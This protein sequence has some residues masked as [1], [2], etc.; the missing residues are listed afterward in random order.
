M[1]L[2]LLQV[3]FFRL[4]SIEENCTG[5]SRYTSK[6]Y[7]DL[8]R[9]AKQQGDREKPIVD[10]V[11]IEKMSNGEHNSGRSFSSCSAVPLRFFL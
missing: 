4:P 3:K 11:V 1:D 10:E 9:G 2:Q 7:S 8:K 6:K 5:F